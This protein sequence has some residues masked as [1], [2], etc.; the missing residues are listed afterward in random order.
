ME[1]K[2]I[3]VVDDD[4]MILKL[5]QKVFTEEGYRVQTISQ[6]GSA[7]HAFR[8]FRPHL[9]FIDLM[10]PGIDGLS[11]CR[12]IKEDP[13]LA[14]IKVVIFSAKKFAADRR[15]AQKMGAD[16]YFE[17]PFKIK[18][19]LNK[20]R[21][22]FTEQIRVRFWGVRGSTPTPSLPNMGLGGNTP[23]VQVRLPDR[24]SLL[25]FDAGTGLRSL[26][27]FLLSKRRSWGGHLFLTHLHWDHIQG[28]PF[29][30]PAYIP[31]NHFII[32]GG[33]PPQGTLEETIQI[34]MSNPYFPVGL[35]DM[36]AQLAFRSLAEGDHTIDG[37]Q[38]SCIAANHPG[39]TFLYRLTHEGRRIVYAPDNEIEP[40]G[41]GEMDP[42]G[43]NREKMRSFFRGCDLLIHDAQYNPDEYENRRG[44]GHSSWEE[45]IR[46]AMQAEVKRLA[47]FHYD[48]GHTDEKIESLLDRC[49]AFI[50]EQGGKLVC[51]LAKE[52]DE[53]LI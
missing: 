23:C 20:V 31:G 47:F 18:D 22:V 36:G 37:L 2:R 19:L 42:M 3:S 27:Q 10:M 28:L 12:M 5:V 30:D 25:I 45:V 4:E 6:S 32:L 1:D 50:Q 17:K 39:L 33:D 15:M 29:F 49:D 8:D 40:R 9:V 43:D 44:W 52:G 41:E 21:S 34:Q 14:D 48:P 38:I 11:L 51:T 26:G 53:L 24:E 16:G 35:Q 46:L 7:V 13:D